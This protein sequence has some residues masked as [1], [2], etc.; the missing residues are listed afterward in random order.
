M[1]LA[2]F[3]LPGEAQQIDRILQAFADSCSQAC[4]ESANGKYQL[5]SDDP[6]KASDGAYLLSFSII[7]LN[8][9]QHN[10]NIREDRKM[11][12]KDFIKNNTDYGREI[13]DKGKELPSD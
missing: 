1:F 12:R 6:K 3:R 8:T 4:E 2:T 7:M 11:S 13:T 5:F 9:D 10:D